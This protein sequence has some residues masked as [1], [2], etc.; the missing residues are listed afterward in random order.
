MSLNKKIMG[1][2]FTSTPQNI[3]RAEKFGISTNTVNDVLEKYQDKYKTL[4]EPPLIEDIYDMRHGL[5]TLEYLASPLYSD[6]YRKALNTYFSTDIQTYADLTAATIL[7]NEYRSNTFADINPLE[8]PELFTKEDLLQFEQYLYDVESKTGQQLFGIAKGE[9]YTA[10]RLSTMHLISRSPLLVSMEDV[11]RLADFIMSNHFESQYGF[12]LDDESIGLIRDKENESGNRYL[13]AN[14]LPI[15]NK[16]STGYYFISPSNKK[17]PYIPAL[18]KLLDPSIS[19]SLFTH[20]AK[21][22]MNVANSTKHTSVAK[23]FDTTLR[24]MLHDDPKR[25]VEDMEEDTMFKLMETLGPEE[26]EDIEFHIQM[27]LSDNVEYREKLAILEFGELYAD[28]DFVRKMM[29]TQ[30]KAM[31]SAN[32]YQISDE[33]AGEYAFT[34]EE[35]MTE[36][37]EMDNNMTI[38]ESFGTTFDMINPTKGVSPLMKSLLWSI[39]KTDGNTDANGNLNIITNPLF[40]NIEVME[41][42]IEVETTV[43]MALVD[44]YTPMISTYV[45]SL[46]GAL[47]ET[48]YDIMKEKLAKE[49]TASNNHILLSFYE[50]L[51]K[52]ERSLAET[53]PG[54]LPEFRKAFVSSFSLT[55]MNY[56]HNKLSFDKNDKGAEFLALTL[57]NFEGITT[58]NAQIVSTIVAGINPEYLTNKKGE[59]KLD[60]TV[61]DELA[62]VMTTEGIRKKSKG[63]KHSATPVQIE[64]F[65]VILSD[66]FNMDI[67]STEVENILSTN[68]K[69]D[70]TNEALFDKGVQGDKKTKV[71]ISEKLQELVTIKDPEEYAVAVEVLTSKNPNNFFNDIVNAL[72]N[73]RKFKQANVYVIGGKKYYNFTEDSAL[74]RIFNDIKNTDNGGS[75][76]QKFSGAYN[77]IADYFLGNDL[78]PGKTDTAKDKR[79]EI[80][81]NRRKLIKLYEDNALKEG[82]YGE[83]IQ[84]KD[85]RKAHVYLLGFAK[86]NNANNNFLQSIGGTTTMSEGYRNPQISADG[87]SSTSFGGIIDS[88]NL[89]PFKDKPFINFEREDNGPGKMVIDESRF[90]VYTKYK[91]TQELVALNNAVR[92]IEGYFAYDTMSETD[93]SLEINKYNNEK[94]EKLSIE[95]KR[96]FLKQQY[97]LQNLI[98]GTHF[99]TKKNLSDFRNELTYEDFEKGTYHLGGHLN[100]VF[101]EV[102]NRLIDILY[103][104]AEVELPQDLYMGFIDKSGDFPTITKY[105]RTVLEKLLSDNA[106]WDDYSTSY[107][108]IPGLADINEII[109]QELL[110]IAE[111][112]YQ[113]VKQEIYNQDRETGEIIDITQLPVDGMIDM[114]EISSEFANSLQGQVEWMD[115]IIKAMIENQEWANFL[116]GNVANYKSKGA[117]L[118]TQ[119]FNKRSASTTKN[120]QSL[121]TDLYLT[122]AMFEKFS[123]ERVLYNKEM[124]TIYAVIESLEDLESVNLSQVQELAPNI[125]SLM[126]DIADGSSVASIDYLFHFMKRVK[127]DWSENDTAMFEEIRTVYRTPGMIFTKKH[128]D[129]MKRLGFGPVSSALKTFTWSLDD[130]KSNFKPGEEGAYSNNMPFM[131]KTAI[132]FVD[133]NMVPN[134]GLYRLLEAMEAQG[135]D[136]VSTKSAVKSNNLPAT[137]IHN[138]SKDANGNNVFNGVGEFSTDPTDV[139]EGTFRL[140]PFPVSADA[141]GRQQMVPVKG[142]FMNELAKQLKKNIL[143]NLDYDTNETNYFFQGKYITAKE[144][145]TT[146]Q[147]LE[148]DII[149]N[150]VNDFLKKYYTVDQYGDVHFDDT[151]FRA[152]IKLQLDPVKDA[153]KIDILDN[154]NIPITTLINSAQWIVPVL[155]SFITKKISQPNTNMAAVVQ[156]A[157]IGYT[158]FSQGTYKNQPIMFL[159]E[160]VEL[161]PPLPIRFNELTSEQKKVLDRGEVDLDTNPIIYFD[162]QGRPTVNEFDENGNKNKRRISKSKML[163]SFN[164]L[165]LDMSYEQFREAIA[166]GRIDKDFFRSI[167]AYRI[168][169]QAISSNDSVEIVGILPPGVDDQMVVYHEITVK[170]GS[171]FDIDKLFLMI[172]SYDLKLKKML[173]AQYKEL[174]RELK[175]K[176]I[177]MPSIESFTD[178]GLYVKTGTLLRALA[179]IEEI[180][181]ILERENIISLYDTT[182]KDFR[183]ESETPKY[184]VNMLFDEIT[185]LIPNPSSIE[186]ETGEIVDLYEVL[187][188]LDDAYAERNAYVQELIQERR[189]SN[190]DFK[191]EIIDKYMVKDIDSL[192]LSRGDSNKGKMNAL[193]DAYAAI[194]ESPATYEDLM[195]PLDSDALVGENFF[196]EKINNIRFNKFL[197][198]RNPGIPL[199]KISEEARTMAR[200]LFDK[201]NEP[202]IMRDFS[203]IARAKAKI[204][205]DSSK[206]LVA[207]MA[208]QMTDITF[209]QAFKLQLTDEFFEMYNEAT[210]KKLNNFFNPT[211]TIGDGTNYNG[212]K[213]VKTSLLVSWLMNAAVDAAKDNY[214]VEGNFNTYT[215][216]TATM[217]I[218]MGVDPDWVFTFLLSDTMLAISKDNVDDRTFINN[219]GKVYTKA[220]GITAASKIISILNKDKRNFNRIFSIDNMMGDSTANAYTDPETEESM[221][222]EEAIH[223]LWSY[224]HAVGKSFD[225][226]IKLSKPDS[227]G[228]GRSVG[229]II[230]KQNNLTRVFESDTFQGSLDILGGMEYQGSILEG[231]TLRYA[232]ANFTSNEEITK[233]FTSL[234]A[235]RNAGIN[236]LTTLGSESMLELS[237]GYLQLVND[238]S[239]VLGEGNSTKVERLNQINDAVY[240]HL[241]SYAI[242]P[243]APLN[244]MVERRSRP[245]GKIIPHTNAG[246]Q[247]AKEIY[248]NKILNKL[249]RYSKTKPNG[250]NKVETLETPVTPSL[251][252]SE[253]LN[254]LRYNASTFSIYLSAKMGIDKDTAAM[255]KKEMGMLEDIDPEFIDN[256]LYYSY[257][258]SGLKSNMNSIHEFLPESAIVRNGIGTKMDSIRSS[259]TDA[260]YNTTFRI[261]SLEHTLDVNE[262]AAVVAKSRRRDYQF[263]KKVYNS[264]IFESMY[265]LKNKSK[266]SVTSEGLKATKAKE[267][268][269]KDSWKD[270]DKVLITIEAD[271]LPKLMQQDQMA[272]VISIN[273]DKVDYLL[274]LAEVYDLDDGS[275][276]AEYIVENVDNLGENKFIVNDVDP[277]THFVRSLETGAINNKT[278]YQKIKEQ[279]TVQYKKVPR[280]EANVFEVQAKPKFAFLNG[281]ETFDTT[282]EIKYFLDNN[283]INDVS[284]YLGVSV[285]DLAYI[286]NETLI[287]MFNCK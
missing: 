131:D 43:R 12:T 161:K 141:T 168:P 71:S 64:E 57:S 120:T 1:C 79:L 261:G 176:R 232:L 255:Y 105:S 95:N 100:K 264:S 113:V 68:T 193:I 143:S 21:Q 225:E 195:S 111:L 157:N 204:D 219:A 229:D 92:S 171:D 27:E 163:M 99:N 177:E 276:A 8:A 38:G 16:D 55:S 234:G 75:H 208:N 228:A 233:H 209:T 192:K 202:N 269:G 189:K 44:T 67:T 72:S 29:F 82:E 118:S 122:E 133:K 180:R 47:T 277:G 4:T 271:N 65:R 220:D 197:M 252:T 98:Q 274:Y 182:T 10:T 117:L 175:N 179:S 162:S 52:R 135:V 149:N 186:N 136:V 266:V 248:F 87:N 275:I 61:L 169:N 174:L 167:I 59:M 107:K 196:K 24:T 15:I 257:I 218:R 116:G 281:K 205:M 223:G 190:D 267:L 145:F 165:N 253:F 127:G 184:S 104:P 81:A 153:D 28:N 110:D 224:F 84:N 283:T 207:L 45:S 42:P 150:Q 258:T 154:P 112:E 206:A 56:L 123:G 172:P 115:Y 106:I 140:N 96:L 139:S 109:K 147:S 32:Q 18:A 214:I 74:T 270:V 254:N 235:T 240:T 129:F 199:D 198:A 50:L 279:V 77:M 250:E 285:D 91:L 132:V 146:V 227:E 231:E 85:T 46:A 54:K 249:S 138:V 188:A 284:L 124:F 26:L 14:N 259:L 273:K 9:D 108:D 73:T 69:T 226:R 256:L 236:L 102:D 230:A 241:L 66:F 244:T 13:D 156:V 191:S 158:D 178:P 251:F 160:N 119:E 17:I 183:I 58:K 51:D 128:N 278:D 238:V 5:N 20:V 215:S 159:E 70:T 35:Y 23:L 247:E 260:N 245:E 268:K 2:T 90:R 94:A 39:P 185:P 272:A 246:I 53:N 280:A 243:I 217:L 63:K 22:F 187:A 262:I 114:K 3:S 103:A 121:F 86:R 194:L 170:T 222:V 152:L 83:T 210:G 7:Y 164:S 282:A 286:D 239:A 49:A 213:E 148:V 60:T 19:G 76:L 88:G 242:N 93:I 144:M 89:L 97:M 78:P 212:I 62:A 166:D 216:S 142:I 48:T 134:T 173:P 126:G 33:F 181:S 287:N 11:G 125:K 40:N 25:A 201:Q 31:L 203:P 221:S 237:E 37:E 151:K 265:S 41:N 80:I 130:F 263:I 30:F 211:V 155:S 200:V 137:R 101:R 36:E 34:D 6:L